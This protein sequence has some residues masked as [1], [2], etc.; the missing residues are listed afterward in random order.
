M[1]CIATVRDAKRFCPNHDPE[2]AAQRKADASKGGT[3]QGDAGSELGSLD[4][5]C[6]EAARIYQKVR[7]GKLKPA[8][9]DERLRPLRVLLEAVRARETAS[10]AAGQ[11]VVHTKVGP[12]SGP[13]RLDEAL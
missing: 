11:V 9:A 5:L 4:G 10:R 3:R 2:R 6:R 13:R 8:K 12:G 7:D 1:R